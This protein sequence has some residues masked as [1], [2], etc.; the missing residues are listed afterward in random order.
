MPLKWLA[1]LIVNALTFSRLPT[2]VA[3]GYATMA[4]QWN[5]AI[6]G[7]LWFGLSDLLDGALARLFKV[8]TEKGSRRDAQ[9]D[10]LLSVILLILMFVISMSLYT[11]LAITSYL[12]MQVHL[13]AA[14]FYGR[15][16]GL[17][18]RSNLSGKL[19]FALGEF[20][21]MC[22][23]FFSLNGLGHAWWLVGDVLI[24]IAVVF[25]IFSFRGR[26]LDIEIGMRGAPRDRFIR[27]AAFVAHWTPADWI[28][29]ARGT[30]L[31]AWALAELYCEHYVS[32]VL[33]IIAILCSDGL[34]GL[35]ARWL[36]RWVKTTYGRMQDV[37][38]DFFVLVGLFSWVLATCPANYPLFQVAIIVFTLE[39]VLFLAG[40]KGLVLKKQFPKLT[41]Q[42]NKIGQWKFAIVLVAF[43]S[44]LAAKI[45]ETGQMGDALTFDPWVWYS[46]ATALLTVVIPMTFFTLN[47]HVDRAIVDLGQSLKQKNAESLKGSSK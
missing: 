35:V 4:G 26:V 19:K 7:T 44:Y 37:G 5:V 45:Q 1:G 24:G 27:Y 25:A 21:A 29:T 39:T 40:V 16:R 20:G 11:I 47:T 30:V 15:K 33:A 38:N 14:A 42:P 13:E 28:S 32:G 34:D 46:I 9:F 41:F 36:V 18:V 3:I 22:A 43:V 10:K 8:V 23:F 2:A 12:V 17:Q 31:N 6:W